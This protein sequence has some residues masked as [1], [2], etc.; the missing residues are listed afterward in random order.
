MGDFLRGSRPNSRFWASEA[1]ELHGNST[2]KIFKMS[3]FFDPFYAWKK[4]WGINSHGATPLLTYLRRVST[5]KKHKF[6]D[7]FFRH[8]TK[9]IP[10]CN[11]DCNSIRAP[12][13]CR[14]SSTQHRLD[15]RH[16]WVRLG[17]RTI[18]YQKR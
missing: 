9:R 7:Y 12:C 6:L 18:V 1:D 16:C 10:V 11:P 2:T 5:K 13:P 3:K 17:H 8:C 4:G 15:F 14:T